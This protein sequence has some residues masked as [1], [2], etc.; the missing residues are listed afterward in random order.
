MEEVLGFHC[1]SR[2]LLEAHKMLLFGLEKLHSIDIHISNTVL[3]GLCKIHNFSKAF[4]LYYELV[5][6]GV[7]QQLSCLED[8][9]NALESS[10]KR[11]E[12]E[13]VSKRIPK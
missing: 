11:K 5:E 1:Q 10:G 2:K 6:K 8:L 12:A 3:K 7:H 9:K 13:F 4:Q